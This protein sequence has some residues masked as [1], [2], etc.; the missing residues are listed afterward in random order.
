MTK[1]HSNSSITRALEIAARAHKGQ[2][3]KAG[4]EYIQHP[5][6]V[7]AYLGMNDTKAVV[8]ALLHDVLKDRKVTEEELA[9]DF[10]PEVMQALRALTRMADEDY[11]I[12]IKRCAKNP[13][14]RKV[15]IA[16]LRHNMDPERLKKVEKA[17]RE[18]LCAKYRPAL[19]YLLNFIDKDE[20]SRQLFE[21]CR[22]LPPGTLPHDALNK[23]AFAHP[24]MLESFYA[25]TLMSPLWKM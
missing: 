25:S 24:A 16:D 15:K 9:K 11:M 6:A 13:L 1:A 17:D 21:E 8:V 4:V 23:A 19:T 20:L 5:M 14:A 22:H 10:P 7:A 2:L 12:F 3:D 18:Q